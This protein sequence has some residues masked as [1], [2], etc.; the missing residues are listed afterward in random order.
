[1]F[2]AFVNATSHGCRSVPYDIYELAEL[3][4]ALLPSSIIAEDG[5][6]IELSPF[7]GKDAS[8]TACKLV[9]VI[10]TFLS[11]RTGGKDRHRE[12]A[13]HGRPKQSKPVSSTLTDAPF[14]PAQHKRSREE[15]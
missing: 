2:L 11:N 5:V 4:D 12:T 13:D 1:M 6:Q 8:Q 15:G 7:K 14:L 10:Q 3:V 9:Q